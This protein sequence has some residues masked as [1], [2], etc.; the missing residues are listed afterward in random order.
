ME[1]TRFSLLLLEPGEIYFEDYSAS[2]FPNQVNRE[3]FETSRQLGRIKLCSKSLVFDPQDFN[4]PIIKIPLQNCIGIKRGKR[5]WASEEDN[6]IQIECS[7][8]VEMLEE[9][10]IAAY[11]FKQEKTLFLFLL[12]YAKVDDCLSHILQLYRA[13]TLPPHEQSSMIAA[14]VYSRQSRVS[15]DA[16]WLE[17]IYEKV[18]CE[19]QANK[20]SPLVVNPGRI[21]LTCSRIYFQ[22]YNNIESHS[23]LKIDLKNIT[24]IICRRFLLKQVGIEIFY[25]CCSKSETSHFYVAM[26]SKEVRDKFYESILQQPNLTLTSVEPEIITLK[27]QNRA[28]SNYEYLLYLNSLADRSFNDLTQYPV[29]PWVL[30]NYISKTL[31]LKDSKSYR[32]LTKPIGALNEERL[33]R[34]K[35]RTL[36][37]PEPKFLYGSHYSA[38]G[39]VIFYLVRKYPH[40]MLCLQNGRF[41]HPDR[42]FNSIADVWRNVINNMSDFKEL[43]PE[44]YDVSQSGDFLLNTYGINFGY[45][46]NGSKV[47]DV[48]L[49]PWAEN[50]A[51]FVSKLREALESEYVSSNIHH[52]IDLIFGYKQRGEEAKKANNIYYYLCY[53]GAVDIDLVKDYNERHALEVQIM[54]FGQVPKQIFKVPHP[55]RLPLLNPQSRIGNSVLEETSSENT[56]KPIKDAILN[57]SRSTIIGYHKDVV[58]SVAIS[59]NNKFILS[60]S[61]DST[62]RMFAAETEK[63]I[64]SFNLNNVGISCCILLPD[65]NLIVAGTYDDQILVYD[66]MFNKLIDSIIAHEDTVTSICWGSVSR[67]LVSS[68]RDCTLK[69]W[70]NIYQ[71]DKWHR[72]KITSALRFDLDS[73]ITCSVINGDNSLIG[74]GTEDGEIIVIDVTNKNKVFK[75]TAHNGPVHGISFSPENG[76]LVSCGWDGCFKVYD[77]LTGMEVYSK[78]LKAQL[79][80]LAWNGLSLLLGSNSGIVFLWDLV[81]VKLIKEIECKG[82]NIHCITVSQ[83]GKFLIQKC[84]FRSYRNR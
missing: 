9:N 41:D 36:E 47:H 2:L 81:E 50:P 15:F 42:M 55:P 34:L 8:Y 64:R 39:F 78:S 61:K 76:K 17:D 75:R 6:V 19:T 22:P 48:S 16:K 30:S 26:K 80:C 73:R 25:K 45:R 7:N 60:S 68:S 82:N 66:I 24:R 27:W 4:K 79:T 59:S 65:D 53:E 74:S 23:V 71:D 5:P 69:I 20:I 83:N 40:Y 67:C 70:F 3:N 49:P 54:E 14:I 32:D 46:C 51:D 38:P 33:E 63:Q 37:M 35:E 43:I 56:E 28:I 29:F 84:I 72:L 62:I 44:F 13:S 57:L 31:D 58:T 12:N 18:I 10:V 21:V 1:K 77:L 52:W 11:K